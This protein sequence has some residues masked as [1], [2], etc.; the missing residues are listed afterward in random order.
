MGETRE[1]IRR[2]PDQEESE[3]LHVVAMDIDSATQLIYFSLLL[4]I[5]LALLYISFC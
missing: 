1:T 4:D 2:I 3:T 5:I